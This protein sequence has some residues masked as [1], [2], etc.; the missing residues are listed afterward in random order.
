MKKNGKIHL[1][2][3]AVIEGLGGKGFNAQRSRNAISRA[4]VGALGRKSVHDKILQ[5]VTDP[6]YG[7]E[8]TADIATY[9]GD[10]GEEAL[11]EA[12]RARY[13]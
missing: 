3:G 5:A 9:H 1:N 7:T 8:V 12:L 6:N 11:I 13:Q 10:N 2:S 4:L